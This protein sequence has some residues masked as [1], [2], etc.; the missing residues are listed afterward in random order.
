MVKIWS[1][2]LHPFF[3]AG[4]AYSSVSQRPLRKFYFRFRPPKGVRRA[5]LGMLA[6]LLALGIAGQF[7][8]LWWRP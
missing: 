2:R 4:L 6:I 8:W 1:F 7:L 5:L 3:I